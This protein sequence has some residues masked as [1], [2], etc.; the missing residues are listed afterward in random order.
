[1]VSPIW[2]SRQLDAG[3]PGGSVAFT[4]SPLQE[5][6]KNK[7][8]NTTTQELPEKWLMDLDGGGGV[9][10]GKQGGSGRV[11]VLATHAHEEGG[12]RRE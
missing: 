2:N 5:Q 4:S 7:L 8:T 9:G 12:S 6:K 3:S 10:L 1:M 11:L